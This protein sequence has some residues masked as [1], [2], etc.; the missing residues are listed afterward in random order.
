MPKRG[1]KEFINDIKEAIERIGD[2][3]GEMGY[4]TF[5]LDPKTQD[6]VVRN[7]EII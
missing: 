5:L 2:Y 3:T 4:D 7:I 1:N 6:A